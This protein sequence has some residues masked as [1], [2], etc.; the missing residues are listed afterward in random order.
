V[1]CITGFRD[2]LLYTFYFNKS[3][4][5]LNS[6]AAVTFSEGSL[7]HGICFLFLYCSSKRS[8]VVSW[9]IFYLEDG[10]RMLVWNFHTYLTSYTVTSPTNVFV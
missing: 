9:L 3:G 1:W 7:L 5:F 8:R 6:W 2:R 4:N 10:S